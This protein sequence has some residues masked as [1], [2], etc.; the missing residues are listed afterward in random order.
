MS[1]LSYSAQAFKPTYPGHR[2]KA[3]SILQET[4]S[5]SKLAS[6]IHKVN[7][8]QQNQKENFQINAEIVLIMDST[9]KYINPKLLNPAEKSVTTKKLFCPLT[10]DLENL[11]DESS[12]TQTP[13]ITVVHCGTNDLDNSE[14]KAVINSITNSINKLSQRLISSKIIVSG[15]LARKDF[16]NKEIYNINLELLKRFQLLPN[17]H[18]VDHSDLL[19]QDETKLLVDKKHLNDTGIILFAKNLKISIFGRGSR[20][21]ARLRRMPSPPRFNNARKY[22]F[23]VNSSFRQDREFSSVEEFTANLKMIFVNIEFT[24]HI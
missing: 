12:F 22:D 1:A 7:M 14:P 11:I 9:G 16:S 10:R 24:N 4:R 19:S 18:F 15:L 21:T 17:V 8:A 6:D 20:S 13:K 2:P 23:S 5:H 3:I